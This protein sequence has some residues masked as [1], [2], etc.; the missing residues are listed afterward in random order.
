MISDS[1]IYRA[2]AHELSTLSQQLIIRLRDIRI[3]TYN[4]FFTVVHQQNSIFF[5][6]HVYLYSFSFNGISRRFASCNKPSMALSELYF[7][8]A[9]AIASI[10]GVEPINPK[11]SVF[12]IGDEF[13]NAYSS[14]PYQN[15]FWLTN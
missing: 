9:A 13:S 14:N 7:P 15:K 1:M 12:V 10:S 5:G 4:I 3:L 8:R 2:F 11:T 6:F